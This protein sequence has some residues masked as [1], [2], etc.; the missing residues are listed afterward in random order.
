MALKLDLSSAEEQRKKLTEAQQKRIEQ[1]YR[2][3]SKEIAKQAKK[4]PR[5]PSDII[6]KQYLEKLQKQIDKELY[7][8]QQQL[9]DLI[10]D[11]MKLTA[12]AL[13]EDTSAWI[14]QFGLP[15]ELSMSHVSTEIVQ[16]VVSGQLY[17]GKWTLSKALWNDHMKTQSDVQKVVAQG[18]AMQKSAYDIAKDL[19][20]YVNPDARKDWEWSKVYPGTVKKV[21]YN[22]QRLA[23]TM[24]S[25][26][27][28]QAFVR[29][30]YH[31][32]FVT[33]Y[34]WESANSDR[35]C[36]ICAERDG[37][38]FDKDDLPLDHP[39]GMCTFTAVM[40]DSMEAIADRLADWVSGK[41]DPDLDEYA[42]FLGGDKAVQREAA[43][44]AKPSVPDVD[45]W[46]GQIQ[47]QTEEEMLGLEQRA[48][49]LMSMDEQ[50]GLNTYTS[51]A[52][53]PINSYLRN[54]AVGYS[55]EE[56]AQ[57]AGL[58]S[59][60]KDALE[61]ARTGLNKARLEKDLV[62]RRGTNLGDLAGLL[63]T[64]SG[65]FETIRSELRSKSVEELN[66]LYQGLV[67]EYS[68]FTSTSSLWNRGFRDSVEVIFYAPKGTPAS[69]IM[70][71][72]QY[73]TFE[74]ETLLNAGTTV[75]VLKIE[76]SDGHM[77]SRIRIFMEILSKNS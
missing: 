64:K 67:G 76:E 41:E 25:H 47:K 26:A 59:D 35:T 57:K 50:V 40:E 27:Y 15:I 28:Q 53:I 36:E 49:S 66:S 31:N 32:P 13:V 69:S 54:L 37:Q 38:L 19:E 22:A 33:A 30:T 12:D 73:G 5:V 6:K 51:S 9:G 43:E 65:D 70:S 7:K 75:K 16:S 42:A 61:A 4:A 71:I 14:T 45:T 29:T 68:G 23:R 77:K 46:I 72:S 56:A 21:D 20:K 18:I 11:N 2:Q 17:S 63:S 39:N 44:A 58:I 34:R 1:L 62:L 3:A 55:E 10:K 8:I 52:Y 74:G 24:V 60:Y 48:M